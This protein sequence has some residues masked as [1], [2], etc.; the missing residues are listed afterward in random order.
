MYKVR[1]SPYANIFYTDWLL[2]TASF[3][4]NVSYA[5]ILHG[6]LD[7]NRLKK[8]LIRYVNDHLLLNSHI[9]EINGEPYWV[10]NTDI[11]ELEYF[12]YPISYAELLKYVTNKFDLYNDHLYRFRLVR[13]DKGIYKFIVVL[14]HLVMDGSSLDVGVFETISN[15]Y[16]DE[17]YAIKYSIEDQIRLN[18]NLTDILSIKLDQNKD[19]YEEFWRQQLSDIENIDLNFLKL[20]RS[21]KEESAT[22]LLDNPI[23]EIKFS[24]GNEELAK[25]NQ[26]KLKYSIT[27]YMYGQCIFAML[28]HRYTERERLAIAYPIAIKEGVDFIYGVQLNINLIPYEFKSSITIVELLNQSKEFFRVI[29]QEDIKYSYYPITDLF[30]A[31]IGV[32]NGLLN[33]SFIQAPFRDKPFEFND[34]E[35]V[36]ALSEL[37]VDSVPKEMLLFEQ[38]IKLRNDRLNYRVR[39]DKRNFDKELVSNFVA[40]YKRLFFEILED[41]LSENGSKSITNYSLLDDEQYNKIVYEFNQTD[42]IYPKKTIH[43]LFEEQALKTPHNVAVI[44]SMGS[45]TYAMVQHQVERLAAN[46]FIDKQEKALIAILSEKSCLQIIS[47]LAIMKSGN[48]Y[49]PLSIDWPI[50]HIKQVLKEGGVRSLVVSGKQCKRIMGTDLE[51]EYKIVAVRRM[52]K[53]ELPVTSKVKFPM[54]NIDDKAYVI[55]TSGSTGKPKGVAISHKGAVNTIYALNEKFGIGEHDKVLALSELSF[56]LSVY[57][58]FGLLTS[59][60]AVV[61]PEQGKIR[62]PSHWLSLI[63]RYNITIWNTVPQFLQL[64][65]EYPRLTNSSISSLK[66][67][68]LS[69]DWIPID[70]PNRIKARNLKASVMSLGGATEGSIWSIW[71]EIIKTDPAWISIPYGRAMPNQKMYVLDK[72]LQLLPIGVIGEICI[73]GEGVA[74]GYWDDIQRTE[75]SFIEHEKLG[76][77]YR[78]GDLGKWNKNGY[79]EILGRKDNQIKISGYRIELGEIENKLASCPEIKH[80]I[81]TAKNFSSNSAKFSKDKYI[82]AYYVADKKLDEIAIYD[83]LANQLPEYMLPSALIYLNKLPLTANGKLDKAALPELKFES[84]DRYVEPKNRQEK[85]ICKAFI[86]V[87]GKKRVGVNDDFF[88]LGGNSLKAITLTSILQTNFDVKVTHIFNLRTPLK[89]AENLLISK[90]IIRQK[91]ELVKLAYKNKS[92]KNHIIDEQLQ[93]KVTRYLESVGGLQIDYTLQKPITNILLTGATGFLGCN[94]LNQ[95]LKVTNYKIFLLIRASS[96]EEAINRINKKFQYYFDKTLDDVYGSRVIVFKANIEKS[97]L[98]LLLQE[99]EELIDKVDSII[100][101]AASVKHYGEYDEFYLTNVQA[102]INLLDFSRLTKLKDFHYISTY[103]VLNYGFIL[104]HDE[105]I[106]TEDDLPDSSHQHNN[107]YVQTKLQGEQQVIE[108]RNRYGI[109]SNIYRIGN[110]AFMAEN[111][112]T[113]ENVE[114]NAFFHWLK[115]LLKL[116]KVAYDL[117]LIDVSPADL[118]AQAIVK[119]FDKKLLANNTYHVFNSHLC[120]ISNIFYNSEIQS[121]AI[122]PVTMEEFI[123]DIV[124][125]LSNNICHDLIRFLLHQGWLDEWDVKNVTTIMVLQNRTKRI[126]KQLGFE[127]SPITSTMFDKL[128]PLK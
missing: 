2:D 64:L 86:E 112:R 74:L 7:A 70:L 43:Q 76:R 39:F 32:N 98:G 108:Y 106:Y 20:D 40:N 52:H 30:N 26:I 78:T 67:V 48:A 69:G 122:V 23:E 17:N 115:Y 120:Y 35:K 19:K 127:W 87:L 60:G 81:V 107:F 83:Y 99:Y 124:N 8:A 93:N 51:S 88:K 91:L 44:D 13:L 41:L 66:L 18:T 62:E 50:E 49:L 34:I 22:K 55:F 1:L 97:Y 4:Y 53:S 21:F 68:L 94:L 77:I 9:Q 82:V 59:G 118:T 45:Y 117:D 42:K 114:D 96:R 25:L 104:N 11:S 84:D 31:L 95:L 71:Y 85:L 15:Y 109:S 33:I 125:N 63:K 119:L 123:D 14:Q 103:S 92:T 29:K 47:A 10:K 16:N 38:E 89:L 102:T 105:G 57:D 54:V 5:Q 6:K 46:L 126:L 61:F 56:D 24:Y 116:K 27:P 58:M 121:P 36:E 90:D 12:D 100:H 28:L 3:R 65:M 72:A 75:T 101:A 113:Q 79:I 73:G 37:N 80:A 111:C 110:L 128:E